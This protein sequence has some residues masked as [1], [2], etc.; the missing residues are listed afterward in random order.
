MR[1][2]VIAMCVSAT[3]SACGGSSD[4]LQGLP[5]LGAATPATLVGNCATLASKLSFANTTFDSV[6]DV[7]AG[8]LTVAGKPIAEHCL[9]RGEMNRR[10]S[11]VDG[12][13]YAIGFE[14]R[15]PVAWNGRFFY[16]A[17]GGLDGNVVTATGE[18]GGGPLNNAL[19]M[20]FAVISS[21]AG[22]TSSQ[23]PLFGLD[24]QA[25]IDYGYNA[26]ATL[27]PMAKQA[28]RSAYGKAPDRS[29]FEGCSNGGRHA[30]VAAARSSAEYDGIIAGDPG[31]HLPKAAI[32]EMWGAQQFA[33]VASAT[34]A[35]GLPDIKTGFTAT[36]R[37]LVA[38]RILAKCDA[39][40]GVADGMVQDIKAC[41]A[42]FSL[43]ADVPTCAGN[44]RDGTCLTSAQ[45]DA[46]GNVF[47]GARNSAGA[48]LYASFPYDAG[49]SGAGW[50]QWK[51]SNSITLDPAA[52]AFTFT[53]PPQ[54]ASLLSQ[55]SSYALN[56]SMDTDAPKIFATSGAYAQSSWSFMTPP[57]ETNLSALKQ[58]GAKLM[59]Y[60]GTSDPVFSSND[61]T[62][63]YQRLSAANGG[64]AS[65]F[66]RLYTV[67]GMNHCSGGPA[68]DQFDMLTPMVAWV[69][70]GKAPE[71]I[72]ATA[73]DAS[74][75]IPNSEVPADWGAG[76]TRPLCPY[77][78]VARYKGGDV[79][80]AASFSCSS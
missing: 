13:T 9:V 19:N 64:D 48:A 41:Q 31:F 1:K 6:Q 59:V 57:D 70:Q 17:N 45:K 7:P 73:R 46:I 72:V 38:S 36:E 78:K 2:S 61:T 22:H 58:R 8:T 79:N 62:D 66:A 23:N 27:T 18:I 21:D 39:L 54:D 68:A 40:D 12:K 35:N 69:E 67:A 77:P 4:N 47:S 28:I 30:M 56:F 63:W 60:H 74:N 37:Q 71:S 29:Y 65:N 43:A 75:A 16:Q 80:S 44:V 3:L 52:A 42:N 20:G 25:R 34:T 26:V 50:A 24:P 15:L 53:T 10:V 76:R 51:Q 32:G 55:L 33:K 11:A 49:V 14:M 5:R